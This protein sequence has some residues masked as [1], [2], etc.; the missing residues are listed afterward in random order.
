MVRDSGPPVAKRHRA[1]Q[2]T[3]PP[4]AA[5]GRLSRR[6]TGGPVSWTRGERTEAAEA[7]RRA[8]VASAHPDRRRGPRR[9]RRDGDRVL[10]SHA[11]P[12]GAGCRVGVVA[13]VQTRARVSRAGRGTTGF[14]GSR[15]T[16][17][18]RRAWEVVRAW[19]LARRSCDGVRAAGGRSLW[20]T[21]AR[22]ARTVVLAPSYASAAARQGRCESVR[23]CASPWQD[24]VRAVPADSSPGWQLLA[25]VR[26]PPGLTPPPDAR[27]HP[28]ARATRAHSQ[29]LSPAAGVGLYCFSYSSRRP[30]I[31]T[32]IAGRRPTR[33]PYRSSIDSRSLVQR[34]NRF[35]AS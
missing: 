33:W 13:Q 24:V 28:V 20:R 23:Q 6:G 34:M 22:P 35:S 19:A 1:D 31:E 11:A 21:P 4:P 25:A 18:C 16:R 30:G 17:W 29:E 15:V 10:G 8:D 14:S 12:V 27:A 32:F 26:T 9:S 5:A 7:S 3:A 2:P